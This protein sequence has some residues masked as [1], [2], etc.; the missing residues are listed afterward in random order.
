MSH[1]ARGPPPNR[2]DQPPVIAFIWTGSRS[3]VDPPSRK[4]QAIRTPVA[5]DRSAS[6]ATEAQHFNS[7]GD[8]SEGDITSRGSIGGW[9]ADAGMR[10]SADHGRDWENDDIP[11]RTPDSWLDDL[12]IA[13]S[14]YSP[15]GGRGEPRR[16][17]T[18]G[19]THRP[20]TSCQCITCKAQLRRAT[21]DPGASLATAARKLLSTMPGAKDSTLARH[22]RSSGWP[23][24]TA[25][26]VGR[27]LQGLN[28]RQSQQR[29]PPA[30]K[31]PLRSQ[32]LADAA[33]AAQ[34]KHP[35]L[36]I[37]KVTQK[38]RKSGWP[39]VTEDEVRAALAAPPRPASL[40]P[41]IPARPLPT[42]RTRPDACPA[43]GVIVG[44]LGL[45]RCS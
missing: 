23:D 37:R 12:G 32:R 2:L 1:F 6:R 26:Q 41:S 34:G 19:A 13:S 14:P 38:L 7:A 18:E 42:P 22:L 3:D 11:D 40:T 33:K 17:G 45:C 43:C 21:S 9:Y 8:A 44:Q 28:R 5:A 39:A 15:G 4:N 36:G 24:V 30:K 31:N 35:R 25:E 16:S 20:G 29:P 27:V 10:G